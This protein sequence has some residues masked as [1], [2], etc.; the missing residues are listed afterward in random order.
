MI[1]WSTFDWP[2]VLESMGAPPPGGGVVIGG[3]WWPG[4]ARLLHLAPKVCAHVQG[5]LGDSFDLSFERNVSTF[6]GRSADDYWELFSTSYGPT[7]ALA[8]SLGERRAELQRAWVE[9]FQSNGK[10]V[11]ERPY[12]LVLG[13]RR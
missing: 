12:L 2:S 6:R 4:Q 5:L 13:T 11:H 3:F 10:V 7:K 1:C 9:R 8:D